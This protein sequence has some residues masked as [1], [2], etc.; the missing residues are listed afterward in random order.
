MHV[1]FKDCTDKR[2]RQ[3]PGAKRQARVKYD[4]G[5]AAEVKR[6]NAVSRCKAAYQNGLLTLRKSD[7]AETNTLRC[8]AWHNATAKSPQDG[9]RIMHRAV[10]SEAVR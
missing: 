10:T 1:L 6:I 2:K 7:K 5:S 8:N 4:Y 9:A 3:S